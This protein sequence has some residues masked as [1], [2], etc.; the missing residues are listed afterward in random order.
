MVDMKLLIHSIAVKF[1]HW[2]DQGMDLL[3]TPRKTM[4]VITYPYSNSS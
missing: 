3:F 4:V 2:S 1:N